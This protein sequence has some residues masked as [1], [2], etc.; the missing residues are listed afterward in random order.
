MGILVT[1][2]VSHKEFTG[3]SIEFTIWGSWQ[4]NRNKAATLTNMGIKWKTR[5]QNA[6]FWHPR[7][8]V[9]KTCIFFK[10]QTKNWQTWT[11]NP[12]VLVYWPSLFFA[13]AKMEVKSKN[14]TD[15][16]LGSTILF[17]EKTLRMLSGHQLRWQLKGSTTLWL[18]Y[19]WK[20]SRQAWTEISSALFPPYKTAS[21]AQRLWVHF[22][23][24]RPQVQIPAA[25]YNRGMKMAPVNPL[26][27]HLAIIE[28]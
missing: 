19:K 10:K 8:T 26:F 2:P 11:K 24:N 25:S 1:Q 4:I 28:Q 20:K 17:L 21:T 7:K 14:I 22:K 18:S 9:V 12:C 15:R 16:W 13:K 3:F 5:G 23:C 6:P 27:W